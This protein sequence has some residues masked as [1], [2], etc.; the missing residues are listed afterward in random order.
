MKERK[1]I[2][3]GTFDPLTFGHLDLI[4][5]SAE[6]FDQV[7]LAIAVR[8][9]KQTLF[10]IEERTIFTRDAVKHLKNVEVDTFDGLLVEYA[11]SRG[12]SI[13]IRGIRAYSDFESEFQMALTNRTMAPE[14]ETVFVMSGEKHAFYNSTMVKQI[15]SLGGDASAFAPA[16]VIKRV[17]K[18]LEG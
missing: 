8:S 18:K 15:I 3:A 1:A 4:E 17:K 7:I 5:R 13:L 14:I 2:Y 10:S 6:I 11:R 16:A 12:V 9:P